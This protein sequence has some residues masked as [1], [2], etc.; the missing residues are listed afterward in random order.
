MVN[1]SS[2]LDVNCNSSRNSYVYKRFISISRKFSFKKFGFLTSIFEDEFKS[3]KFVRGVH[4]VGCTPLVILFRILC[5]WVWKNCELTVRNVWLWIMAKQMVFVPD[6]NATDISV[7]YVEYTGPGHSS[8][9]R[10]CSMHTGHIQTGNDFSVFFSSSPS[11]RNNPSNNK[12]W[13]LKKEWYHMC[14]AASDDT[15]KI[16]SSN[17]MQFYKFYK[18]NSM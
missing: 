4:I 1:A 16:C 13:R 14:C 15:L 11:N 10:K 17:R 8:D 12:D 18:G 2:V 9:L 3:G 7:G 5:V 6:R